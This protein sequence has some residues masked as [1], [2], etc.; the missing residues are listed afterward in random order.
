MPPL[1]RKVFFV[2]LFGFAL[3]QVY[4]IYFP[5]LRLQYEA[6]SD[7][8]WFSGPGY[9]TPMYRYAFILNKFLVFPAFWL[10]LPIKVAAV[11][12]C[13]NDALFYLAVALLIIILTRRYD[14]AAA[15]LA[16]PVLIHGA[17]FYWIVN[18]IFLSGSLLILYT[19]IV[20]YMDEG[21]LKKM[22]LPL[23]MFFIIW[24]HPVMIL[25][26]MVF[27]PFIYSSRAEIKRALP[28][29]IFIAANIIVRLYALTG[30]DH[31]QLD[32]MDGKWFEIRYWLELSRGCLFEYSALAVMIAVAIY[33]LARSKNKTQFSGL[34]ITPVLFVFCSRYH[35]DAGSLYLVKI[36]YPITLF[37]FL[38][39]IIFLSSRDIS[40]EMPILVCMAILL[41]CGAGH[42]LYQDHEKLSHRAMVIKK[43]NTLC[44]QQNSGQS[45]WV[46]RSEALDSVENISK[47]WHT[48]SLFFSSYMG[49][50]PNIQ[51][52]RAS[53]SDLAAL[54]SLP[55][56]KIF[57]N[58]EAFLPVKS[59]NPS[60][61][62]INTGQYMELVLDPAKMKYLKE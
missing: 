30:Y 51:L 28:M 1:S 31:D 12:Y 48:E 5:E 60:Y 27:L 21:F 43:L 14:Y 46:V 8:I 53:G 59:L 36:L 22:F 45:K 37:L 58:K 20:K 10:H 23:C 3:L 17:N 29:L 54:R 39:A 6:S 4:G 50:S 57:L 44:Q 25:V 34:M 62:H 49:Q 40:H 38:Q 42:T 55:E 61:F 13:V 11:V 32:R 35:L 19:A 2:C 52:V 24:S 26:L 33:A 47:D 18:E 16:A 9:H 15:V 41:F 56:E 7:M